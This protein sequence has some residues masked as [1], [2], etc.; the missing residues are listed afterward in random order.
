MSAEGEVPYRDR[1]VLRPRVFP[2]S[3]PFG[4][5]PRRL[6][7]L[8]LFHLILIAYTTCQVFVYNKLPKS[9]RKSRHF[10]RVM[11]IVFSG[12]FRRKGFVGRAC[13]CFESFEKELCV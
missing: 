10:V 7:A 2:L 4:H 8:V 9:R 6:E 11:E 5:L 13:T 3:L 12:I 1:L